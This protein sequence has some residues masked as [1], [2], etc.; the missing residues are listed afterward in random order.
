MRYCHEC[1]AEVGPKA[2]ECGDCGADLMGST[3]NSQGSVAGSNSGPLASL[4]GLFDRGGD[5]GSSAEAKT[6]GSS[7]DSDGGSDDSD[8]DSDDGGLL[9]SIRNR[10]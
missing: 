9:A 7:N 10:F 1:E 5:A 2:T 6:D 8:N 3:A 4:R